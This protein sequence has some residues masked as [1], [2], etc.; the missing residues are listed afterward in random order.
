VVGALREA[1]TIING[2]KAAAAKLYVEEEKSKL[3]PEAV[4]KII[5]DPQFIFTVAP[6]GFM[7]FADFMHKTDALKIKPAS[8]R[9]VFFPELHSE[10]GS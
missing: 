6:Q 10:D 8:W 3:S 7:K 4:H 5:S 1:M 9:D 2:D